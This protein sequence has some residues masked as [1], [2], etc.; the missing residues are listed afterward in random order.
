M[1]DSTV[2][3]LNETRKE[4]DASRSLLEAAQKKIKHLVET[5]KK[6]D[7]RITHME[8]QTAEISR[9][10]DEENTQI[11]AQMNELRVR[12]ARLEMMISPETI[13]LI[14]ND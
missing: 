3:L 7:K 4:R 9:R 12:I 11:L 5:V 6:Y 2:D 1:N 8:E 14:Q 10:I 13:H